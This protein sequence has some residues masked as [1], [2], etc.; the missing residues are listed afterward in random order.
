MPY[1][2]FISYSHTADPRL[3]P[4][5]QSALQRFA[6]PWYRLRALHVFRDKT[7]L[8]ATPELWGAIERALQGSAFF[9]LLASPQAAESQWVRKEIQFWLA[10]K[11]AKTILIVVTDGS[12]AWDD[13]RADFDWSK[14]TA[15]PPL[16]GGAF[17]QE[18]LYV[19]LSWVSEDRHFSLHD[20]R[21]REAITLLAAGIHGRPPDEMAGEDIRQHRRT[22]LIA[23]AAVLAII[24]FGVTAEFQR[25]IAV[26]ERDNATAHL[27]RLQ[28]NNALD[29]A[30]NGDTLGA[31]PWLADVVKRDHRNKA[32][33][34][35][36]RV[37]FGMYVRSVP[38]LL[39]SWAFEL[40][41]TYAE[42]SPD[43]RWVVTAHGDSYPKKETR[44]EARVWEVV[45]GQP[46]SPPLLHQGSVYRATF[47]PDGRWVVTASGDKTA[48]IWN[49]RTGRPV[50]DPLLHTGIV[51]QAVWSADGQKL[52]TATSKGARVWDVT[53]GTPLTPLLEIPDHSAWQVAFD[54]S[55][56]KVLVTYGSSYL[57]SA[58]A[59]R[60]WNA[61]TGEPLTPII[62]HGGKW[63]YHGAFSPDGTRFV[64]ADGSGDAQ[65]YDSE[66]GLALGSPIRYEQRLAFASFSPEGSLLLTAGRDG[67]VNLRNLATGADQTLSPGGQVR[68]LAVN[69]DAGLI[70][71]AS[72]TGFARVWEVNSGTAITPSLR[73]SHS[74]YPSP[75]L[76]EQGETPGP[77]YAVNFA[78]DGH[79]LITTGW[80]GTVRIWE[81]ST[82]G[83][84]SMSIPE[85][86]PLPGYQFAPPARR[87]SIRKNR[88]S[89][90]IMDIETGSRINLPVS[91]QTHMLEATLSPDLRWLAVGEHS[92]VKRGWLLLVD[93]K[94]HQARELDLAHPGTVKAVF[95]SPDSSKLGLVLGS[96]FFLT[97]HSIYDTDLS[98]VTSGQIRIWDVTTG[99]ALS[100]PFEASDWVGKA[101]FGPSGRRVLGRASGRLRI[102]DAGTG[103]PMT[104]I[105][106]H[107]KDIN[108]IEFSPD[109]ARIATASQ[110][111]TARVWDAGTGEALTLPLRHTGSSR[112]LGPKGVTA[113][114]FGKDGKIL[115]TG[116]AAGGVRLWDAH[117]GQELGP[118]LQHR[119]AVAGISI[120]PTGRQL[121]VKSLD[122]SLRTWDI[123]PVTGAAADL[124]AIS[125]ALATRALD[126]TG[127]LV[128]V[129]SP[130]VV[131]HLNQ[132]KRSDLAFV[133]PSEQQVFLWHLSRFER[134]HASGQ[135]YSALFHLNRI[136]E[137]RPNQALWYARRAEVH[138]ER[139][140]FN[141]AVSDYSK[142]FQLGATGADI[143]IARANASIRLQQWPQAASDYRQA[144]KLGDAR[145]TTHLFDA[146]LC[147]V[148]DDDEHFTT[149]AEQLIERS[150]PGA[151]GTLLA[152]RMLRGLAVGLYAAGDCEKLL[153]M[154]ENRL[155][156]NQRSKLSGAADRYCAGDYSAVADSLKRDLQP[157]TRRYPALQA[158]ML[159]MVSHKMGRPAVADHWLTQGKK[160]Q[161]ALETAGYTKYDLDLARLAPLH[162][163]IELTS[164]LELFVLKRAA[165]RLIAAR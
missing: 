28:V 91:R 130:Q 42:F 38:R 80:D 45:S 104:A 137:S 49:P 160:W 159:A 135:S 5:V 108:A 26:Q 85:Q 127:N 3:P 162:P 124:I 155:D 112:W 44:G 60:L 122:G 123:S 95:F 113:I 23:A 165:E 143:R 151:G 139:G 120:A 34:K 79:R 27:S 46:V 107:D 66:S 118:L 13:S 40:P 150:S 41:C 47:S 106:K 19:D 75:N 67:K 81:L 24:A 54:P 109:S 62:A 111:W 16:L 93:A 32:R 2:A 70:A 87:F 74:P 134:S 147:L 89:I 64:T 68:Q 31:L 8:A 140:D 30:D 29:R 83:G 126:A 148:T 125:Q 21:F 116:D 25:R 149:A 92:I 6:R 71:T 138:A 78:P 142:A 158:Y 63:V 114:A 1:N 154:L 53:S 161:A 129:S 145:D 98:D 152:A 146:L 128:Q 88:D 12:I 65:V 82:A 115:A 18:P 43:G 131:Q 39:Q 50:S 56:E 17:Q 136:L 58:G 72:T 103:K 96:D 20:G 55:A 15:L 11:S 121:S 48:R 22:K 144:L 156:E 69:P 59:V 36:H 163:S 33:A 132:A 9:V 117:T 73:I 102:W 84:K 100:P 37:R 153:P 77:E 86:P 7:S 51:R 164:K 14:T 35:V 76:F 141:L 157:N 4:A 94:T 133:E 99:R 97:G 57:E 110:D 61:A 52:A 101:F 90:E 119:S 105:M 10:N